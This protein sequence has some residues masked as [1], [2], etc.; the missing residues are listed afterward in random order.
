MTICKKCR[1]EVDGKKAGG[2]LLTRQDHHKVII[3]YSQALIY[4][5]GVPV[6]LRPEYAVTI[7]GAL[8]RAKYLQA[9]GHE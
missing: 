4:I 9:V 7:P 5:K 8:F 2:V 6:E 1:P 3:E